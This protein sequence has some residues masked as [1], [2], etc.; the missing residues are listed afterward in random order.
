MQITR[1]VFKVVLF[2]IL[3]D[4]AVDPKVVTDENIDLLFDAIDHNNNGVISETEIATATLY[5][6]E[7]M[8][9]LCGTSYEGGVG[10][11]DFFIISVMGI[12]FEEGQDQEENKSG[13]HE[14]TYSTRVRFDDEDQR[15]MLHESYGMHTKWRSRYTKTLKIVGRGTSICDGKKVICNVRIIQH[16]GRATRSLG[17]V[18]VAVPMNA[19]NGRVFHAWVPLRDD[20]DNSRALDLPTP[21]GLDML[22]QIHREDAHS[23]VAAKKLG[24]NIIDLAATD[25]SKITHKHAK[26]HILIRAYFFDAIGY[27]RMGLHRTSALQG[28]AL[29]KS[30]L[31]SMMKYSDN[32]KMMSVQLI[33]KNETFAI[34]CL[35]RNPRLVKAQ[36]IRALSRAIKKWRKRLLSRGMNALVRHENDASKKIDSTRRLFRILHIILHKHMARAFR[37]WLHGATTVNTTTT[38]RKQSV[39]LLARAFERWRKRLLSRGMNALVRHEND[40][41][42]RVDST[43]RLVRI[44]QTMLHKLMARAFRQW[45]HGTVMVKTKKTLREQS[46]RLLAR[47]FERWQKRLLS[48]GMN[49]LVRHENDVGKRIDSTR[50]LF[51]TLQTMC[52]SEVSGV[53]KYNKYSS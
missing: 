13:S 1:N 5:D 24:L 14:K 42:K 4:N 48:R 11:N 18:R 49:A 26:T 44:L 17:A 45:M 40:V 53:E 47:A 27:G 50:R 7:K 35:A 23:Y 31:K 2:K 10:E 9:E 32:L 21:D 41:G 43:R 19:A 25:G 33:S 51:R 16:Q 29:E 15:H 36:S 3:K 22:R 20:K 34:K 39:R 8:N 52:D 38:L 28:M 12:H 46:V 37:Q 6:V 30:R